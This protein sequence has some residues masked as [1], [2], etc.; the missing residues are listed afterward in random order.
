MLVSLGGDPKGKFMGT[1]TTPPPKKGGKQIK[2]TLMGTLLLWAANPVADLL[3]GWVAHNLEL[4]HQGTRKL[5]D[6][7]TSFWVSLVARAKHALESR[8]KL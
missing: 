1:E 6:L 8:E 2:G 4:P 5:R 3:R 7:F